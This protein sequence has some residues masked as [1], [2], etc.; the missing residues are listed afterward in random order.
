MKVAI[1]T[2]PPFVMGRPVPARGPA[3]VAGRRSPW[4][5]GRVARP[6]RPQV[7]RRRRSSGRLLLARRHRPRGLGRADDPH[8]HRRPAHRAG[9]DVARDLR[10]G[11]VRR[12][13][14]APR[15][16]SG[17]PSGSWASRSSPG[18]S[19]GVGDLDPA[20]LAGAPR[21]AD[22]VVD[23]A[24]STPRR[25]AV[26]PAPALLAS[27]DPDGRRRARSSSPRRSPGEW[28][29][30]TSPPCPRRAG[31]ASSTCRRRQPARVHDRSPGCSASR[32]C[33]ACPPT[34]T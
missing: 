24:R 5:R 34:P 33:R 3:P 2:L 1:D 12:A 21:V 28:R 26:L 32:R 15:R 16:R 23:R 30:S 29:A 18:P 10:A 6:T 14:A 4:H 31:S 19:G 8:R 22:L 9:A 7:A 25:R 13:G 27:G 17:S 11:A 20:G